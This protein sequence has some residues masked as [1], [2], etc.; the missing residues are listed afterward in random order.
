MMTLVNGMKLKPHLRIGVYEPFSVIS[1]RNIIIV[2]L[3][4]SAKILSIKKC[5]N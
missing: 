5:C 2:G 4:L 1:A 3:P